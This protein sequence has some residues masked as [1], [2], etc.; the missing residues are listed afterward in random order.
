MT[1]LMIMSLDIS[2]QDIIVKMTTFIYSEVISMVYFTKIKST[3]HYRLEH[4]K[5]MS[6]TELVDVLY[7]IKNPRRK[8]RTFIINEQGYYVVFS[9]RKTVIYV[10]NAK[11]A[12]R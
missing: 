1:D 6:W 4:S 2:S 5:E 12:K 3:K 7:K 9:M 8:G 10:I 11:R